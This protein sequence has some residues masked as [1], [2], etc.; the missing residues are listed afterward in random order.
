MFV[1]S[2]TSG[3]TT[4]NSVAA[5]AGF[6]EAFPALWAAAYR[7]AFRLLG[8]RD[9]ASDCAQEACARTYARWTRLARRGDPTPWAVR[10]SSNLAID[11]WRRQQ[12]PAPGA[13]AMAASDLIAERIDLHGALVSL[14]RRQREV[15]VL[16]YLADLREADVA[17]ALGITIGSVKQHATRGLDALRARLGDNA[18]LQPVDASEGD[19]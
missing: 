5:E 10:V 18:D 1:T 6:I 13:P 16:K 2:P 14:P 8:D 19:A 9:D 12:R 15:I 11:H 4:A 7:V 17:A 3:S